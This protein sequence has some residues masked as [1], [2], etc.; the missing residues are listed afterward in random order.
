MS[1]AEYGF[2]ECDLG[3][4]FEP[5]A[6]D[7]AA[8]MRWCYENREEAAA[9]GRRAARWLEGWQAWEDTAYELFG[10]MV[11]RYAWL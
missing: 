1:K 3:E 8:Q 9:F 7:L 2:W 5:D 11:T 6:D 10:H 4:W